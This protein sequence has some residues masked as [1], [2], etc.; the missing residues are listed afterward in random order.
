MRLRNFVPNH[1]PEMPPIISCSTTPSPDDAAEST[2]PRQSQFI[3]SSVNVF[4]LSRRYPGNTLPTHDPE[5]HIDL[6]TLTDSYRLSDSEGFPATTLKIDKLPAYSNAFPNDLYH[7]FPNKSPYQLGA[8]FYNDRHQKSRSEFRRLVDIVGS[9]NFKPEDV[10]V[11]SW[12]HVHKSLGWNS[13]NKAN[14]QQD[15]NSQG[16]DSDAGWQKTPITITVPFNH[17]TKNPGTKEFEVGHLT[18]RSLVWVICE[19][20]ANPKDDEQFHYEP[21]QLH[22]QPQSSNPAESPVRVQSKLYTSPA[23]LKAHQELQ[24]GPGEPGCSLPRVVV[25]MMFASDSTHLTSFGT[26]K[27]WPCYLYFGNESKYR[28]GK[29]S[30]HLCNHVAYLQYVSFMTNILSKSY[31]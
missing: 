16:S 4:G 6:D 21:F 8:W 29:P 26:A 17:A 30:N 15:S 28:R 19:K 31:H 13:F 5:E 23:F 2:R 1:L 27:V 9:P 11:T 7:P 20:L 25:A 10:R 22:W 3:Q 12:D 24:D 14:L 18:H